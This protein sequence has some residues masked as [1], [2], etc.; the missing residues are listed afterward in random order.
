MQVRPGIVLC[1]RNGYLRTA[2]SKHTASG[3][4]INPEAGK[5]SKVGMMPRYMQRASGRLYVGGCDV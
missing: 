4:D 5:A 3:V 2:M 1:L